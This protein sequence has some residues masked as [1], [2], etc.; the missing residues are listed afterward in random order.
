MWPKI[1][2]V[3]L[4][5]LYGGRENQLI[6]DKRK[7]HFTFSDE[8]GKPTDVTPTDWDKDHVDLE[9]KLPISDGGAPIEKFI[10]EKKEP[11][12]DWVE[13][14]GVRGAC[15]IVPGGIKSFA[16][17]WEKNYKSCKNLQQHQ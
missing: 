9:W 8:P 14:A 1:H 17:V 15:V 11:L 16:R 13:A 12:G 6:P 5:N 3:N 10:I 7:S 4:R 2:L